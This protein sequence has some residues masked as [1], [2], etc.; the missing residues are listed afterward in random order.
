MWFTFLNVYIPVIKFV[1]IVI[2]GH[3]STE[4]FYDVNVCAHQLM[5]LFI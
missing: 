4:L 3:L 1:K 2:C 5:R